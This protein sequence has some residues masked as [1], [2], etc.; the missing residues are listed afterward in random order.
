MGLL[1]MLGQAKYFHRINF[2]VSKA[3]FPFLRD[4]V[5]KKLAYLR[6]LSQLGLPSPP[7]GPI[8]TN[9]NWD[10]FEHRY[11]SPPFLQLGQYAF[12]FF[13]WT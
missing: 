1:F 5:K 11:P 4:A 6:T 12:E 13:V 10:I 7:L 8:R 9:L 3:S 2:K